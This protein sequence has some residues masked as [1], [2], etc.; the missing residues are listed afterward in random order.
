MKRNSVETDNCREVDQHLVDRV[1][2]NHEDD[3]D[4]DNDDDNEHDDDD[5]EQDDDGDDESTSF[6]ATLTIR[7]T[8]LW[9][10]QK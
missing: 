9:Y 3:D 5:Y 2:K 8:R 6:T 10:V 1:L 4:D 7:S